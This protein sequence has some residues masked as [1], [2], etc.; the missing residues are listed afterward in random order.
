M[1][2]GFSGTMRAIFEYRGDHPEVS[3][4]REA[5]VAGM[6]EEEDEQAI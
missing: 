2:H 6:W 4:V 3:A 5:Q 1:Y